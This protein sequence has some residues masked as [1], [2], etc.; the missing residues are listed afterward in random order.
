MLENIGF[1]GYPQFWAGCIQTILLTPHVCIIVG[2]GSNFREQIF[3]LM[4]I[5]VAI[6][7]KYEK[8]LIRTHFIYLNMNESR[9]IIC[10]IHIFHLVDDVWMSIDLISY[11]VEL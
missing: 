5:H 7:E 3:L 10:R 11:F 2:M 1:L 6:N 4:K 9:G 8:Q